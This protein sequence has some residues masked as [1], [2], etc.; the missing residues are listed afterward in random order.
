M[1][2]M[3]YNG[4]PAPQG[5]TWPHPDKEKTEGFL[6][7]FMHKQI[8]GLLK[9]SGKNTKSGSGSDGSESKTGGS[10]PLHFF[11]PGLPLL[12]FEAMLV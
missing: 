10:L 2:Q 4:S 3:L 8:D 1:S 7:T 9:K 11:F 5:M 6:L 12:F